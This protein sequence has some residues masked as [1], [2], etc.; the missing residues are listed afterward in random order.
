M[1][2]PDEVAALLRSGKNVVTP[3]GRIYPSDKQAAPL[4]AAAARR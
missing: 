3:V 2:N 4:R 1:P